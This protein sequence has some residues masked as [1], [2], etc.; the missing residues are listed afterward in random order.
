LS[1]FPV[2]FRPPAFAS[3]ASC[4]IRELGPPY[5][6]LTGP[7]EGAPDPNGV[8]MFHTHE[9]R[10]GLGVLFTPGT[11]VSTR[12]RAILDRRLPY[13]NGL[14][15]SPRCYCPPRKVS[16]TRHQQ[17]FT[18][19]H[20]MPSLPFA[21]DSQT[22]WESLGFPVS[23]TPDRT[24]PGHACHGRD[25]PQT[26]ARITSPTSVEPPSTSSLITRDLTSHSPPDLCQHHPDQQQPRKSRKSS[27]PGHKQPH[28]RESRVL[29]N[30]LNNP[31]STTRS[32]FPSKCSGAWQAFAKSGDALGPS[33]ER[34]PTT[35]CLARPSNQLIHQIVGH[36]Q[37][38]RSRTWPFGGHPVA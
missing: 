7:P 30:P 12:S 1:R 8:S 21:C 24:G 25:G 18:V 11:A 10:L 29:R 33:T 35:D 22:A 5:G 34:L 15:L 17:G 20:P 23:F 3:W 14:S 19:I 2:A 6:R 9:K 38:L 37:G 36:S 32:E 28:N 16:L 31:P 4:P 27:K 13:S 26:L